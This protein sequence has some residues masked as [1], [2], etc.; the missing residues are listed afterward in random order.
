MRSGPR[1]LVAADDLAPGAVLLHDRVVGERGAMPGAVVRV[2]RREAGS[3][4]VLGSHAASNHP[5]RCAA[6]WSAAGWRDAG[7]V[8]LGG[9]GHHPTGRRGG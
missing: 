4:N 1:D 9:T 2:P 7:S 3:N 6:G 5:L 8:I